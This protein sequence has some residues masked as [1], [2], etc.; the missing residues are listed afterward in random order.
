MIK[1]ILILLLIIVTPSFA[2][3]DIT[4]TDGEWST[5]FD[6]G[7]QSYFPGSGI[8]CDGIANGLVE[9]TEED[10]PV[11]I[12]ADAN[13]ASGGGGG[14]LWWRIQNGSVSSTSPASAETLIGMASQTHFWLRWYIKIEEGLTIT[15]SSGSNIYGWKTFYLWDSYGSNSAF[16]NMNY[17]GYGFDISNHT[18]TIYSEYGISDALDSSTSS[19]EWF[20]IEMEFDVPNST[21]RYWIY[22]NNEDHSDPDG[23]VTNISYQFASIGDI[24]FPSNIRSSNIGDDGIGD[25]YFDD[26]AISTNGRIGPVSSNPSQSV[27]KRGTFGGN[28]PVIGG[29]APF[30]TVTE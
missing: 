28:A 15:K 13:Y 3:A 23:E 18:T 19:G 30:I 25:I 26:I 17:D 29:K 12:T 5:T 2:V 14:G 8:N 27:S 7:E 11:V 24:M 1:Q 20:A 21:W 16:V 10:L 9:N 22:T 6:C 4:L